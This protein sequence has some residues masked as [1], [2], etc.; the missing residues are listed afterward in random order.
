M[1]ASPVSQS[2]GTG[3]DC[4]TS[5]LFPSA[6]NKL[7]MRL[8]PLNHLLLYFTYNVTY[9]SSVQHLKFW[10]IYISMKSSQNS[11]QNCLMPLGIPSFP[12]SSPI[13]TELL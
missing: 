2:Q 11:G 12:F 6:V 1:A 13:S 5:Y 9:I 4:F 10:Q 3:L 7:A 8:Q